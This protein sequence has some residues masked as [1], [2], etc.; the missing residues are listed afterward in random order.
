MKRLITLSILVLIY[1]SSCISVPVI[2]TQTAIP[3]KKTIP[4][5]TS[6]P[7]RF[8]VDSAE[9][10]E[11]LPQ[12]YVDE[13]YIRSNLIAPDG[14]KISLKFPREIIN[15]EPLTQIQLF[16]TENKKIM[17]D[18]EIILDRAP[19]FYYFDSWSPDSMSFVGG[20]YNIDRYSGSE[21]CCGEAIA[22]TNLSKNMPQTF[23][24]SWE[25]IEGTHINWSSDSSKLSLSFP[26]QNKILIVDSFGN[27]LETINQKGNVVFW[28]KNNLYFTSTSDGKTKLQELNLD[29]RKTDILLEISGY[30]YYIAHN[31][32]LG[33]IILSKTTYGKGFNEIIILDIETKTIKN[34]TFQ[35]IDFSS[36]NKKAF[37]QEYIALHYENGDLWVFFWDTQE[38]KYYGQ[39]KYL[40]DWYEKIN[41]FLIV[42]LDNQQKVIRP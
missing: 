2:I 40:F 38:T 41:G 16:S 10:V 15:E 28:S 18:F 39:V 37:N 7:T 26:H 34:V 12:E 36:I 19:T 27:L 22:I 29:T 5:H 32:K 14:E 23:L 1:S 20:Y 9:V 25:W 4:S 3:T 13:L 8:L 31:E 11:L 35:N 21:L 30:I 24:Y 33:Q 6:T 17:N 42:S